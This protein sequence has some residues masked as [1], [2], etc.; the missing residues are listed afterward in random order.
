MYPQEVNAYYLPTTN[1]ICFPAGILQPPFF[2]ID[3]ND[4][5]NYGAIGSVIEMCIRD[6]SVALPTELRIQRGKLYTLLSSLQ[7]IY[8]CKAL[9]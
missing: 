9:F 7:A 8:S 1:E 5:F 4:A 2:D 3:A 6:R